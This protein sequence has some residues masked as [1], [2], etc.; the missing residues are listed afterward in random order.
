MQ[1]CYEPLLQSYK[2]LFKE[3]FGHPKYKSSKN[4]IQS[5]KISNY[6]NRIRLK[7]KQLYWKPFGTIGLRGFRPNMPGR[8]LN[9]L[10]KLENSK[11]YIIINYESQH[12]QPLKQNDRKIGIDFGLNKLMILSDGKVKT[13]PNLNDINLKIKN[14]QKNYLENNITVKTIK[15][16]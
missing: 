15:K 13:K 8:I 11:W 14:T 12:P 16:F 5:V 7:G 3:K 2:K 6:C 10:I 4:N 9:I 1:N